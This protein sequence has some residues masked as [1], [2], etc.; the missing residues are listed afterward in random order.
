MVWDVPRGNEARGGLWN[1]PGT[2]WD[3]VALQQGSSGNGARGI[4]VKH[5]SLLVGKDFRELGCGGNK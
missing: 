4:F 2:W 1:S 5:R 3:W